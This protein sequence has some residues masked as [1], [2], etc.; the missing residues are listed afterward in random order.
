MGREDGP[1]GPNDEVGQPRKRLPKCAGLV[2]ASGGRGRRGSAVQLALRWV[3]GRS[4]RGRGRR[5]TQV[6]IGAQRTTDNGYAPVS[7]IS[8]SSSRALKNS[9]SGWAGTSRK[10]HRR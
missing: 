6:G 1:Q 9:R 4:E 7:D 5:Q 10:S 8:D 2:G 3:S